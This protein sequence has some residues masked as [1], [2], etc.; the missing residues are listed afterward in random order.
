MEALDIYHQAVWRANQFKL[1]GEMRERAIAREL[2]K[3]DYPDPDCPDYRPNV[4]GASDQC[5]YYYLETCLLTFPSCPGDCSDFLPRGD[6][7]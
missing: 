7:H 5:R 1:T 2:S 6:Q 4:Q 3:A